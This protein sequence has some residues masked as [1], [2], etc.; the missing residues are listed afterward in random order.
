MESETIAR[1]RAEL[2]IQVRSGRLTAKAAAQQLGVSRKTYYKW[3]QRAL[4]GMVT[5]LS[6]RTNGRPAGEHDAE[7]ERLREQVKILE[8]ELQDQ[9]QAMRI[10]EI[11][12]DAGEKKE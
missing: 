5:A 11:M 9:D 3:E 10:K 4:E 2:I 8:E 7:R 1:Q 12:E 6:E